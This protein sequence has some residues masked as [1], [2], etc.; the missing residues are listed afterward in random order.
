MP[1][2]VTD[3]SATHVFRSEGDAVIDCA[4]VL[5]ER[6][7]RRCGWMASGPRSELQQALINHQR[8][9]HSQERGVLV[10]RI[11]TPSQ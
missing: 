6:T 1:R 9:Y 10:T 2:P 4:V 5:D 3:R 11:N 7:G 8:M